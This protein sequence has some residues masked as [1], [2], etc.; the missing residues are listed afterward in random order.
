[1]DSVRRDMILEQLNTYGFPVWYLESPSFIKSICLMSSMYKLDYQFLDCFKRYL[2]TIIDHCEPMHNF[3]L[4]EV[5]YCRA[6]EV[7]KEREEARLKS[8]ESQ[9]TDA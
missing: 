8:A 3:T 1:M 5:E 7:Q 9:A 6:L 2:L 4:R